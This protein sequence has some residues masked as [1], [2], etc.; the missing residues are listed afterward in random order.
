VTLPPRA[1]DQMISGG[2]QVTP[3][4]DTNGLGHCDTRRDACGPIVR[5]QRQ[6]WT[7]G[8]ILQLEDPSSWLSKQTAISN[9]DC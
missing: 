4:T 5:G 9:D 3:T 7:F 6:C 8:R 1:T 2:G